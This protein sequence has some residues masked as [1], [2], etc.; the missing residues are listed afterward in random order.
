MKSS[1]PNWKDN[2][3]Y[4]MVLSDIHANLSALKAVFEHA[5]RQY[6]ELP[7][8]QLGDI[9]DYGMRPNE[10]MEL[11]YGGHDQ[12]LVNL[13]GNHEEAL[14]GR[15]IG[16]FSS[17]RGRQA[18]R[19]TAS[20][21]LDTWREYIEANFASH[22][23]ELNIAGR[24]ILCVHGDLHDHH[25]GGMSY[26]ESQKLDY[27]DYD[28]VLSG[29]SH[30]RFLRELF[31]TDNSLDARRGKKNT[32]FINPGSV[33]QPRNHNA[34]AQ[35]AVMDFSLGEVFFHAVEYTVELER[36]LYKGQVDD[37]YRDRLSDGI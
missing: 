11:L 37:F 12:Y 28:F 10:C 36:V 7:I 2:I 19:Y 32:I 5:Q 13:A 24:K 9:V 35:Y 16:R 4:V 23:Q 14:F 27:K 26:A 33:G 3:M 31:Y 1:N 15:G 18:S 22:P 6:G 17:E 25:W 34:A 21:L 30:I 20:I 8:I 29:H